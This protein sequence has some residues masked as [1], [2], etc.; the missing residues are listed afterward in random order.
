ME[1]RQE[2][3]R[4]E[5]PRQE[6]GSDDRSGRTRKDKNHDKEKQDIPE[7]TDVLG[8]EEDLEGDRGGEDGK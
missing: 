7:S 4:T 1:S 8:A 5:L 6:Q 3:E 2:L